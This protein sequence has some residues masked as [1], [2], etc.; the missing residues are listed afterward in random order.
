MAREKGLCAG[1]DD[2][3]CT[4][5]KGK[6]VQSAGNNEILRRVRQAMNDPIYRKVREMVN[7][8]QVAEA[9]QYVGQFFNEQ[10]R[11]QRLQELFGGS[12]AAPAADAEFEKDLTQDEAADI[13]ADVQVQTED[14]EGN[15]LEKALAGH[16]MEEL[17]EAKSYLEELSGTRDYGD[18]HRMRSAGYHHTLGKMCGKGWHKAAPV[19]SACPGCDDP[20]CD[21]KKKSIP[22][23]PNW[24]AEEGMEAEHKLH[25]HRMKAAD[26]GELF[27]YLAKT[28][29]FGDPH[30]EKCGVMAKA[31]EEVTALGAAEDTA[32]DPTDEAPDVG[33]TDTKNLPLSERIKRLAA[34]DF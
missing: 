8:G 29:D 7:A 12:K 10:V 31:L 9:R 20:N 21:C 24:A 18:D 11:E 13:A 16:E 4:C 6:A 28:N 34:L 17:A 5:K 19:K 23:D 32:A 3:N 27:G 1:C 26:A 15:P 33:G 30:R 22:G 25:P 2:P 14:T